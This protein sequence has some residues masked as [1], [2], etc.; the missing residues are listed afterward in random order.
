MSIPSNLPSRAPSPTRDLDQ[1]NGDKPQSPKTA[2]DPG[3]AKDFHET[4][5]QARK[6]VQAPP[7]FDFSSFGF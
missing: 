5:K 1:P 7:E 2:G 4:L 3:L 6:V